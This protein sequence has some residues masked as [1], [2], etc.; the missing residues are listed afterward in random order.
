MSFV[1]SPPR[2]HARYSVLEQPT[3]RYNVSDSRD[4]A[5]SNYRR[6]RGSRERRVHFDVDTNLGTIAR[7]VSQYHCSYSGLLE[8]LQSISEDK[9]TCLAP[10]FDRQT[11]FT[12]I[13]RAK[14]LSWM[15]AT[16]LDEH[17]RIE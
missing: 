2:D 13:K 8:A 9:L 16:G 12:H 3:Q 15:L 4:P 11:S 10:A 17:R 14:D 7:Y 5:G 6:L 1:K